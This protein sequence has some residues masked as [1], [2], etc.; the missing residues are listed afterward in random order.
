MQKHFEFEHIELIR[1]HYSNY[2]FTTSNVHSGG[3]TRVIKWPVYIPH[4][5]DLAFIYEPPHEKTKQSAYVKPKTQI[6]SL[7]SLHRYM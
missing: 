3:R 1:I 2:E 6:A 7:F 5:N 4:L